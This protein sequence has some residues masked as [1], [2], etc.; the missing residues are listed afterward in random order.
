MAATMPELY[1]ALFCHQY[2]IDCFPFYFRPKGRL[3]HPSPR[4]VVEHFDIDFEPKK[5][6]TFELV[7]APQADIET[8][9]A[10][11]VGVE[12][13]PTGC[14]WEEDEDPPG[15]ERRNRHS[16]QRRQRHA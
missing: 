5:G 10:S 8:L 15:K 9:T 7:S 13:V 2:G 11:Q 6:E 3:R 4:K 14:W 16:P 1:I 12:T